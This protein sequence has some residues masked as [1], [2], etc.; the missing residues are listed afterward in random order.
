MSLSTTGTARERLLA[1]AQALV[2]QSGLGEAGFQRV[3]ARR[4]EFNEGFSELLE[5][6]GAE[7]PQ[8]LALVTTVEVPALP[9]LTV[10]GEFVHGE[11]VY[12]WDNFRDH[13]LTKEEAAVEPTTIRVHEL[14]ED[15]LDPPIIAELG[16][17]EVA[18]ISAGQFRWLLRQQANGEEE[19]I[20][21]TDGRANVADIRD[22]NGV[23]WAVDA[24]WDG[25]DR[26]WDVDAGPVAYPDGQ[27]AGFQVLSRVPAEAA[28]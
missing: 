15:A 12:L 24:Y 16:G 8:L 7:P 20:L 21:L 14:G 18:E 9:A 4:E 10:S 25:G 2:E 27:F 11:G 5:D 19:G 26:G 3:L 6:L 1:Q 22:A 17:E 23:L 28:A 13:F